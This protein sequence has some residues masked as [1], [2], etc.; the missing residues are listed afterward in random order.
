V[1]YR[2]VKYQETPNPNAVKI[3][4]D[5]RAGAGIRSY[6]RAEDAAAD[7]LGRAL[8]AVPG[9]TN[10]LINGDWLTV[11]KSPAAPWP[12]VKSGVERALGAAG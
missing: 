9:V 6:F 3:Y 7:D 1:G 8:F 12:D 10:V 5:R 11:N 4:L 2:I